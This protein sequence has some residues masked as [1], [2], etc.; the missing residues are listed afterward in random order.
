MTRGYA[1]GQEGATATS[2][3]F[4]YV[5]GSGGKIVIQGIQ[6]KLILV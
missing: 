5:P 6:W 2:T 1:P 4:K 3:G